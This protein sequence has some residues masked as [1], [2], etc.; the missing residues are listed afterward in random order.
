MDPSQ[1]PE[2]Q[3]FADTLIIEV[4]KPYEWQPRAEWRNA[5][6]PPL[7][8][9]SKGT[10]EAVERRWNELGIPAGKKER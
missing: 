9:P 3:G 6:F 8:Y 4:V 10:M 2:L 7:A 5:R 1:I